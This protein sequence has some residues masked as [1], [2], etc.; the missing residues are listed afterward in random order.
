[1]GN[2]E[3]S[4]EVPRG[5]MG[6]VGVVFGIAIS[7]IEQWLTVVRSLFTLK[8]L[9]SFILP[10]QSRE[11][12]TPPFSGVLLSRLPCSQRSWLNLW[13]LE[14]KNKIFLVLMSSKLRA[15]FKNDS[16]SLEWG[17]GLRGKDAKMTS[18]FNEQRKA[19]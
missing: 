4:R 16:W 9:W 3:A 1:V 14:E 2:R 7:T 13:Y 5:E 8:E 19:E 18:L 6:G 10:F 17:N 11:P 12:R 15:V